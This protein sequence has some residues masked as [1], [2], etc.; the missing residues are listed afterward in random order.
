MART[1]SSVWFDTDQMLAIVVKLCCVAEQSHYSRLVFRPVVELRKS[2]RPMLIPANATIEPLMEHLLMRRYED[3][4]D[5][6]CLGTQKYVCETP[7]SSNEE[8][9]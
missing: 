6:S 7:S 9:P 1:V 4:V 3:S 8:T 5:E 2:L